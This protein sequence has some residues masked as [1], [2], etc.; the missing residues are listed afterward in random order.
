MNTELEKKWEHH[1][2]KSQEGAAEIGVREEA[3]DWVPREQKRRS[4]KWKSRYEEVGRQTER[5]RDWHKEGRFYILTDSAIG[6]EGP[7][8][9]VRR[10]LYK[11]TL[12]CHSA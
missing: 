1:Y 8:I 5:Q 9:N 7:P 12:D 11:V 2:H 3:G 10:H 6:Q 4:R